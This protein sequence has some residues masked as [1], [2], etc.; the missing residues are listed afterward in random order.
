MSEPIYTLM[1]F[2]Q[3]KNPVFP[4]LV[5]G[6][7]VSKS[8]GEFELHS[9]GC[10]LICERDINQTHQM[11]FLQ[12]GDWICAK[13]IKIKKRYQLK[14]WKKLCSGFE[15]E[16]KTPSLV[17]DQEN[18]NHFLISI[19]D[20]FISQGMSLVET[21][22]L[23]ESPGTEP[24]LSPFET[25][26]VLPNKKKQIRFLPTSP[27]MNLKKLLCQGWTDIFEIKK[28]F[29]NGELSRSHL[30]EFY[31]L[32]WYRA[33]F[34][35]EQLMEEI[36]TLLKYLSR[37]IFFKGH[38]KSAEIHTVSD[39]FFKYLNFQLRPETSKE[40]LIHLLDK[41][42]IPYSHNGTWEDFFHLLFLN[43]IEPCFSEEIPLI[44]KDYPLCLRGFSRQNE[45]GW[46][47]RFELYWRGFELANAFYEVTDPVEQG[48]LF[49]QHLQQ[50]SDGVPE[51]KELLH[52]MKTKGMPPCSGIAL[53]LDRLFAAPC[54][55]KEITFFKVFP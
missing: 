10:R 31:M 50:R 47:D 5:A 18:W 25:E 17:K 9:Q 16:E 8:N 36:E 48:R 2:F 23:V 29:R 43:K 19:K 12:Q 24:H 22:S 28:C 7:F 33:F 37:E 51:D 55:K 35:L 44:V 42:Q 54:K 41:C 11:S 14:S 1:R 27:E 52:L 13:I 49:Q 6:L 34:P 4:C 20:F 46:A 21:P 40:D 39:L 53:G 30:P 38:L 32:E 15:P 26:W 3:E 45:R